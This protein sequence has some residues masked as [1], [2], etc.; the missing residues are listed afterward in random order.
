MNIAIFK[1]WHDQCKTNVF[2]YISLCVF[3][4]V[5]GL[6]ECSLQTP[7]SAFQQVIFC[8]AS[9]AKMAVLFLGLFD[10]IL[11]NTIFLEI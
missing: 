9:H 11:F 10:L 7:S 2:K 1:L 4:C 6:L 3:L 8:L 5:Q